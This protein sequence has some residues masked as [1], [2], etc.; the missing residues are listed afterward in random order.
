MSL[1]PSD[2][3]TQELRL[4]LRLAQLERI[5]ESQKK[6]L[7]F[8]KALWP[9]FIEGKHHR[10]IADKLERIASGMCKPFGDGGIQ[11]DFPRHRTCH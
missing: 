4:K 6:F 8:V 3:E 7:T 5:E 2:F 1:D 9:D 11:R 10:L